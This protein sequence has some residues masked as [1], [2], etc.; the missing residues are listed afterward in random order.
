MDGVNLYLL[1]YTC[2]G[3][4]P[5][6]LNLMTELQFLV[7]VAGSDLTLQMTKI[8]IQIVLIFFLV[9][10]PGSTM[11]FYLTSFIMHAT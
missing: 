11:Y 5:H 7:L 1:K 3:L 8:H 9:Y 4:H 6:S 2:K 10:I